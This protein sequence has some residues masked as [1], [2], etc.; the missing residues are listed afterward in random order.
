MAVI[1]PPGQPLSIPQ[2]SWRYCDTARLGST[3]DAEE[4]KQT[5]AS[6]AIA[7]LS[8]QRLPKRS[9][10][11]VFELLNHNLARLPH[12]MLF[13]RNDIKDQAWFCLTR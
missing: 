6:P 4:A 11:K 12:R 7:H 1:E 9:S 5:A 8:S 13:T 10:G 3:A 2:E